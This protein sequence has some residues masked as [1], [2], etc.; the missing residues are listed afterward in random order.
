MDGAT[1]FLNP[2]FPNFVSE[3]GSFE[4]TNRPGSI[5]PHDIPQD[6]PWRSGKALWCAFHHGS[7]LWNMGYLGIIDYY[8]L[9]LN[10]WHWYRETLLG[11]KP[12]KPVQ[13]GVPHA[14]RLTAD[15]NVIKTD[16]TEDAHVL[17]EIVDKDGNRIAN[18][19]EIVLEVVEGGAM[20]PTGK[21]FILSPEKRNFYEGLGAIELRSYYSGENRILAKADGLATAELIIH[22]VGGE[23]W[24]HQVLNELK[25]PPSVMAMPK[26]SES[27]NIATSRPVF[28]SS[29]HPDHPARSITDGNR[30]TSWRAAEN[31]PQEWIMVDLEGEKPVSR[32]GIYFAEIT[33]NPYEISISKNGTSFEVIAATTGKAVNSFLDISLAGKTLRY[34][35]IKFPAEPFAIGGISIYA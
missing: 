19:T 33:S 34:L 32:A 1:I 8:R 14:L 12:P 9:P 18:T 4:E 13:K 20:F 28:A 31:R 11:I 3:Y 6:Y 15:K 10:S 2:G 22:A 30:D 5:V 21:K 26:A 17:V 23:R 24:D 29:A 7:I 25:P 35:R 27:F 16:G